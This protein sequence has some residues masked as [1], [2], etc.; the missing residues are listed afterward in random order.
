MFA[1]TAITEGADETGSV[2][3]T[4]HLKLGRVE[5]RKKTLRSRHARLNTEIMV[6][7]QRPLP[8]S[9]LLLSLKRAR[10]QIKDELRQLETLQRRPAQ[11]ERN[12]KPRKVNAELYPAACV[13]PFRKLY[14]EVAHKE[15]AGHASSKQSLS[16]CLVCF[17]IGG[18]YWD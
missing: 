12:R 16:N 9:L 10:L 2:G 5:A 15:G 13:R 11:T 17:L 8:D 3:E 6:E 14:I 18:R 7:H 4:V 1:S